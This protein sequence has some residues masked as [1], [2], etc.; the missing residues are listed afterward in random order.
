[1]PALELVC[2]LGAGYEN[3][4]PDAARARGIA[5]ANGAGTGHHCAGH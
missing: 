2:A 3:V 4:G 1:M 5:L